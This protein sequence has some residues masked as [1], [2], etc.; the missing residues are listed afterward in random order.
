MDEDDTADAGRACPAALAAH[1]DATY[2]E[3]GAQGVSWFQAEPRVSLELIDALHL[4]LAT[5]VVDVGGG[6][7]TLVDHLLGRSF[8]DVTVLDVSRVGL[9]LA[10]RRAG[11]PPG[12]QWIAADVRTW[13]PARPYG[14]WHDRAVFHFLTEARDQ[15]AYLDTLRA[16][17]PAGAVVV[18]TFA[19]DGPAACS[20]LPVA[21]YGADDLAARLAGFDVVA[22][23][24]EVHVTPRG[25]EQPFTYVAARGRAG[26]A[27]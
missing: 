1:W 19:P 23:R 25:T 17:V 20:G 4:G 13:A 7:S 22:T 18:A 24:R 12:V 3:R 8:A 27:P 11:D 2:R 10:R 6:A 21:R 5:P 14:L 9:D 26:G 15:D 16:A